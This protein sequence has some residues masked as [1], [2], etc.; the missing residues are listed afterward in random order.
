MGSAGLGVRPAVVVD[1]G[2]NR[3]KDSRTNQ[4]MMVVVVVVQVGVHGYEG[5]LQLPKSFGFPRYQGR[6][7]DR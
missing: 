3:V 2:R 4:T 1:H 6:D 7:S 5:M